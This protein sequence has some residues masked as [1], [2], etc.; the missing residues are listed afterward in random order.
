[1]DVEK[2][3][4]YFSVITVCFKDLENLKQ[5][6]A[7]VRAQTCQDFE[8]IVVD[9][10]S[11]DGTKPWLEQVQYDRLN[12]SSEP[13]KGL[14]D[15]MN[16]GIER[17]NGRYLVFMNS[18]DLF[19]DADVLAKTKACAEANAQPRFMYGDSIDF[20][21]EGLENLRKARPAS[22]YQ[23]AMFAQHQAMFFKRSATRYRL[24]YKTSADY[25]FIGETLGMAKGPQDIVYLGYCVCRFLLGGLNEQRR[26]SALKEDLDIRLHVF[27][28]SMG[29]AWALY[30][31]HYGHSVLKR[32]SPGLGR[33][34]RTLRNSGLAG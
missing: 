6:C 19:A 2:S 18:G 20:S 9:G 8:W 23:S 14:Y 31:T 32:L 3:Q 4:P 30:A 10:G 24:K 17:S 12:W 25:A 13:D 7:S 29:K 16:K 28:L 34:V 11:P 1:M 27:G 5:T 26:F 22:S 21:A 15:A 33:W